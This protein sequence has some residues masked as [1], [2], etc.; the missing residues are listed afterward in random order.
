MRKGYKLNNKELAELDELLNK[1]PPLTDAEQARIDELRDAKNGTVPDMPFKKTW[2]MLAFKRVVR[3]ASEN[4]FDM[5]S[6]DTGE[7][8]SD[9]YDLSKQVD[10]IGY[11][12]QKNGNYELRATK[13]DASGLLF[14]KSDIPAVELENYVGKDLAE[15]ILNGEGKIST[16]FTLRMLSHGTN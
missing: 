12:K 2:P 7:V 15:K 8:Q 6:W 9:R 5:I 14:E 3:Y 13:K 11:T 10:A 1:E 16:K 4:G